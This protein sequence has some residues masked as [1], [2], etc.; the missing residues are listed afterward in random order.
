MTSSFESISRRRFFGVSGAVAGSVALAACGSKTA[1]PGAAAAPA[2]ST[3]AGGTAYSGPSV[4]LNFWNG[5]TGGDGD[6]AKVMIDQF[7]SSTP[8]IKVVQNTS[9][10]ADFYKKL[11]GAVTTGKGP[12]IAVMHLD[13]IATNA[14]QNV[15]SPITDIATALKLKE[16]DFD[17]AVW[18]GGTYKG[19]RYGIPIDVHNLGLFYNKDLFE[20]AGLDPEKAPATKDEF[21]NALDKLK[22]KG[23]QGNWVT[24]FQFTGGLMFESL[25]WQFGGDLFDAGVTKAAWDS[26]AGVQVLTFMT[27]L[28]KQGYSPKNVAQDAD[29]IALK[30]SQNAMNWQGIWQ[31]NDIAKVTSTKIGTAPLPRIGTQGGVWGNSHQFVLP[32]NKASDANKTEAARY[33][34]N[35]FTNQGAAWAKSAKVPAEKSQAAGAEFKAMTK[36]VPFATEV[37]DV[38]FPPSVA[39]VGDALAKVYDAVNAAVLGKKDPKSALADAAKS[40]TGILADNKKRYGG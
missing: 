39:G 36:L 1:P 10:W 3:G 22:S 23:I 6:Q 13:T 34:I 28:I 4:S 14:A 21:M 26:D 35:W 17:K 38:H 30:N 37:P 24:P 9:Q 27:D 15:L 5:W 40:A 16:A 20:K 8:N 31:V 12:D 32:V 29:Y 25:L 19:T 7:N 18:D 33:F 11:P 2:T